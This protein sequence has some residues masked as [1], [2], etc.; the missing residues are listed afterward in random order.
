MFW[1]AIKRFY[2]RLD[3]VPK[4]AFV[5]LGCG[6]ARAWLWWILSLVSYSEAF[7]S[8]TDNEG[9]FLFDLGEIIGFFL[10]SFLAYR[11]SPFFKRSPFAVLA[12]ALTLFAGIGTFVAIANPITGTLAI[13]LIVGGGIGY[14]FLFLLWLELFGCLTGRSML[15]A[16]TGSY[17]VALAIWGLNQ[18]IDPAVSEI[19]MCALP[20]VSLLML[21]RGFYSIPS[22][23]LPSP[24][25]H[26]PSIPWKLIIVLSAFALAFGIG[27]V[28][29]G[30]NMFTWVSKVGMGIPELLVLLCVLFLYK[31]FSFKYLITVAAPFIVAGLIGAFFVEGQ[32]VPSFILMNA[33]SEIYLILVYAIACIMG[34]K[35]GS[36][37]VYLAGLFAGLYKVF[38]QIGK[39]LGLVVTEQVHNTAISVPILALIMVITTIVATIILIQDRN[40]VDKFSW[41]EQSADPQNATCT[42]ISE[43]YRL[44][45]KEASIL[46][47]LAKKQDTAQIAED[48]FLAQST[49]RVHISSIYKKFDIHSRKELDKLLSE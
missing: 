23:S 30:Q 38:L 34:H 1:E 9:H 8:F 49:V 19:L 39:M 47:L 15:I 14:A 35:L 6:L 25:K 48:L 44:T 45:P 27:D 12:L 2:A 36:S 7:P 29:T 22:A 31:R 17:F 5:F 24:M 37:S 13:M 46:L 28:A 21:F 20:L 18:V 3:T 26:K 16:W 33:S 40:I 42:R 43:E 11:L 10:L 32:A 4:V 41:K